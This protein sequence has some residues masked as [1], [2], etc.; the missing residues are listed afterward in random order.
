MPMLTRRF[1]K[2]FGLYF[3]E[4][5]IIF[6]GITFSFLFDQWRQER[7]QQQLQ[8]ETLGLIAK[9]VGDKMREANNDSIDFMRMA[10]TIDTL[11]L[12]SRKPVALNS[13]DVKLQVDFITAID[14]GSTHYFQWNTATFQQLV[15]NG[16]IKSIKND[17]L[18][19]TILQFY[20]GALYSTYLNYN[21]LSAFK[22]G[23]MQSATV[24][25][26]AVFDNKNRMYVVDVNGMLR[27]P[28]VLSNMIQ[29]KKMYRSCAF[30]DQNVKR[31]ATHVLKLISQEKTRLSKISF[32]G[33]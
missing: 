4:V 21:Q 10:L 9:D 33:I 14:I 22:Y 29:L 25:V 6:L 15:S 12:M 31:S 26:P 24:L 28:L 5:T 17:S 19:R 23:Q 20:Q 16:N 32:L 1:R 13:F 27:H 7:A 18:A 2:I 8:M 3:T 11:F 30:S